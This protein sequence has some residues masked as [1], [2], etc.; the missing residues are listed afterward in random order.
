[1]HMFQSGRPLTASVPGVC[2]STLYIRSNVPRDSL[3]KS[4]RRNSALPAD[5]Q[6]PGCWVQQAWKT[7]VDEKRLHMRFLPPHFTARVSEIHPH[8]ATLAAQTGHRQ[9]VLG[10]GTLMHVTFAQQSVIFRGHMP[11]IA[12]S[13]RR[14]FQCCQQH[15]DCLFVHKNVCFLT[16]HE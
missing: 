1:M 13:V 12:P 8:D 6:C 11:C 3:L 16:A 7:F 9:D 2:T 4:R 10:N 15:L 5:G 14:R